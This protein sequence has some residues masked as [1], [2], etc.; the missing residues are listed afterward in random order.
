MGLLRTQRSHI[1]PTNFGQMPW[2]DALLTISEQIEALRKDVV[3]ACMGHFQTRVRLAED[4]AA[5]G[6]ATLKEV[7]RR[8]P[9][10]KISFSE[11]YET[12]DYVADANPSGPTS[13]IDGWNVG[14]SGLLTDYVQAN[15]EKLAGGILRAL[16]TVRG[17]PLKR[18]DIL[19]LLV[20]STDLE[21]A[22]W[23]ALVVKYAANDLEAQMNAQLRRLDALVAAA[24]GLNNDD[25]DEIER[26]MASDPFLSKV[27][28]R[29]PGVE[30]RQQGFRQLLDQGSRYE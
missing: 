7:V 22:A 28:P 10:L 13:T 5:I 9:A 1:Y 30:I 21:T 14:V 8:D 12:L 3:G 27:R 20:P 18:K 4:L 25:L 15:D 2:T 19:A 24:F 29:Y 11:S 16:E 23:D 6:C 17:E 26:D